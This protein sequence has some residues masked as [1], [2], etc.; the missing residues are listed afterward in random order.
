M[1]SGVKMQ[2]NSAVLRIYHPDTDH[3]LLYQMFAMRKR[4]FVDQLGWE[5][6]EFGDIE[7][8]QYDN[9][10]SRYVV[11]YDEQRQVVGCT[12]LM[13]TT[14]ILRSGFS[15]MIRDASLGILDGLP[16]DIIETAPVDQKVWEAT[17]FAV[18]DLSTSDR[19]KVLTKV[20]EAAVQFARENG[21][22]EIL[23]LMSPFFLRWLPRVGFDVT[24][25]GPTV[26]AGG[27]P[28]CVI[29]YRT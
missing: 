27:S 5:L 16:K 18:A 17:R 13:P 10:H 9:P 3:D 22:K 25:A 28:C 23:G 24:A 19:N 2:L 29:R 15:Y 1:N 26:S 14:S 7:V 21:I 6:D 8:D 4:L 20:C 11:V 12:R